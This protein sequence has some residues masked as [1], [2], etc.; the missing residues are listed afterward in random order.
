MNPLSPALLT[1]VLNR[2]LVFVSGKGGVGKTVI[3][4]ALARATAAAQRRTLWVTFEDP[5]RAWE[6]RFASNPIWS[7]LIA[8]PPWRLKSMR[9]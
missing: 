3:A 6:K 1:S 2:N 4:E 5:T 9:R 8:N 7:T